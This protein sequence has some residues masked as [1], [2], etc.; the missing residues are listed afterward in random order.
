ME[1]RGIIFG[2]FNIFDNVGKVIGLF[3]GGLMIEWLR[4]M[5]YLKFFVY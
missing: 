2:F 1:D 5:G 4:G 3:F